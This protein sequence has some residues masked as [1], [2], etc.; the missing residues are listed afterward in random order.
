[1]STKPCWFWLILTHGSS[2]LESCHCDSNLTLPFWVDH[3]VQEEK[4][5][6]NQKTLS[7]TVSVM[8]VILSLTSEHCSLVGFYFAMEL[9]ALFLLVSILIFFSFYFI[10]SIIAGLQC[11]VN[12]L[13]HS[14]VTQS[15][16]H[17]Y[18]VFS[19][20]TMIHHKWLD[21]IP[22]AIQQWILGFFFFIP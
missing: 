3:L 2:F 5:E 15:H 18:I 16:I 13:L 21:I 17:V 12:F 6:W 19:H 22:S 14:K 10:F 1:M 11:S 9:N 8:H 7:S 20:I 4:N